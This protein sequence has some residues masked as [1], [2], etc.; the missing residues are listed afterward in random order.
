MIRT[1]KEWFLWLVTP[2]QK[3]LQRSGEIE[4]WIEEADAIKIESIVREGDI[5]LSYIQGRP[6]SGLIIGEWD[7]ASIVSDKMTIV[8]AV[9]DLF[10]DGKNIGGVREQSLRE[11]IFKK[12][13]ICIVRPVYDVG[14][15]VNRNAA[16]TAPFYLG[17]SYDYRFKSGEEEIYC[18]ELVYL[19]Y[20]AYD[21]DFLSWIDGEILPTLYY[22]LCFKN[23]ADSKCKFELVYD[24]NKR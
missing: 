5:I 7:H 16:S 12:D 22:D 11:F 24:S 18:S 6:T 10:K 15:I 21:K 20:R 8:E 9:G 23:H 1:L 2:I 14:P 19:C 17:Y 13:D 4:A 3:L